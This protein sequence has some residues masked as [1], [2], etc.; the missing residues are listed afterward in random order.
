MA[1]RVNDDEPVSD[2]LL[3]CAREQLDKAVSELSEGINQDP[4]AA[5]HA[6]R[7]AIKKE[8]SLL[9]LGRGAIPRQQRRRDNAALRAAARALSGARDADVTLSSVDQLAEQ[10]AGQ[11]P[12]KTF[13]AIR[14][15]LKARRAETATGST[16]DTQAIPELGAVRI[17]VDEW[18]LRATGWK[19]IDGGLLRTYKRGRRALRRARSS[20]QTEDLHAWRKRVK[21]LWYHERLL[22]PSCGEAVRGHAK[23]SHHLADLLGDDHDLALLRQELTDT[24]IPVPVDV[25]AVVQLI[26]HRR[27]ELQTEAFGIGERLYAEPPKA[28]RRRMHRSWKAGR[29]MARA[30]RDRHP[31]ELAA[32]TR[33]ASH[34]R[35]ISRS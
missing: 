24:A 33:S 4:A 17:R 12:A 28:Y 22:A 30:M 14:K 11:V 1:Y 7:K 25:D 26:D 29:A 18:Q 19:A 8:R 27:E 6:A 35:A 5:V 31:A 16:L 2:A 23:E 9:R 34:G 15:Q 10:F 13:T 20:G 21:D 32:A 3:R